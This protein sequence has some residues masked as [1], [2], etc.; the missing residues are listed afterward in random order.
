[1]REKRALATVRTERLAAIA[2]AS[3][4]AAHDAVLTGRGDHYHVSF[5]AGHNFTGPVQ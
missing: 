5:D 1:V 3:S 2:T 4:N